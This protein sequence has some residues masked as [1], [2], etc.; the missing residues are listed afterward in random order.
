MGYMSYGGIQ[1]SLVDFL[2]AIKDK[3]DIDLL[4]WGRT[5]NEVP[6]PE[7]VN[8]INVP[9]VKSVRAALKENGLFSFAFILSCLGVLRKKR[10]NAMPKLKKH[11]DIAIAY[12]QVGYPKYYVIDR[13]NADKK[14]TFYHHGAYE[15]TGK[16]KEWDKE[17]Y[18]K[19]DK[20]YCVSKHVQEFLEDSLQVKIS[21]D[22]FPCG[23]NVEKILKNGEEPCLEFANAKGIKILTVARLSPEKNVA[24][25]IEVAE[26]LKQDGVDFTWLILGDG[27]LCCG[28][29]QA[30]L[31]KG[32]QDYV[33]LLGNQ[34]NPYKYMKNCDVYTQFSQF[35]ACPITIQE[36][37]VFSKPMVL[38]DITAFQ[39]MQRTLN[40]I[41]L[42]DKVEDVANAI[43]NIKEKNIVE[44][45]ITLFN[46]TFLQ[47]IEEIF[48][49]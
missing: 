35:E 29:E 36:A 34:E 44:N 39:N 18:P 13:V 49:E 37:G 32:L 45:D 19:Y 28:L 25:C 31:E 9:T 8:I 20:V 10:W 14:Y 12:P 6:L 5:N 42:Y 2:T 41:V 21:Y 16:L 47:K 15:F 43:K 27:E 17:Y 23:L 40:N 48:A 11:Y 26:K 38:S 24:K 4:L 22:I 7:W 30:I 46:Q 1:R 3:A 33:F